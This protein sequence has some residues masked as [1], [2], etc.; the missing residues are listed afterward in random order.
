MNCNTIEDFISFHR[1]RLDLIM[2][3]LP[4][5]VFIK[6]RAGLYIDCNKA[7]NDFLSI[8]REEII[9]KSVYDLWTK[10]EADMFFSQDEE[11]FNQGGVQIYETKITSSKGV[12]HTVQF[13]KQ[14]FNDSQ[15]K[16]AGFLGVIFDITEKKKLES[17][18]ERLAVIDELTGLANRRDGMAQLEHLHEISERNMRPYC[19]AMIDIDCFKHVNDQYGHHNGDLVL[20]EFADLIKNQLR[21]NDLC[22]RYGGEEFV[23]ILPETKLHIG[24]TVVERLRKA[25]A[26]KWIILSED[27]RLKSTISIG[28]IQN[29]TRGTSYKQL[30]QM[31]DKALYLAKNGGKN[32]SVSIQSDM[33]AV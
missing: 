26:D 29:V 13:H 33:K 8:S 30:L 10:E 9:G 21:H 20:R 25:W 19:I 18:L 1:E 7:F 31:S 14:I 16:M 23:I 15:G 12:T 4:I 6:N 32:C 28:I 3:L 17:S 27:Q 22:F 11:L 24:F 2:D 5:P